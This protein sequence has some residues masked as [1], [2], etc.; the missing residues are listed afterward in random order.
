MAREIDVIPDELL[1]GLAQLYERHK[2]QVWRFIRRRVPNEDVANDLTA[3]VF[4]KACEYCDTRTKHDEDADIAWLMKTARTTVAEWYRGKSKRPIPV[5]QLSPHEKEKIWEFIEGPP[6]LALDPIELL[7]RELIEKLALECME[8]LSEKQRNILA[9]KY[10]HG[11]TFAEAADKL[12][13]TAG[14][15]RQES[16]RGRISLGKEL[17]RIADALECSVTDPE[18]VVILGCFL[19]IL[20]E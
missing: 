2:E 20:K 11:L 5:S 14:S 9:L 17:Q 4:L 15:A 8:R 6:D 16:R 12:K 10:G 19:D 18:I 1:D 13:T 7:G 3:K